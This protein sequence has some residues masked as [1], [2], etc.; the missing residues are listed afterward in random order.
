MIAIFVLALIAGQPSASM[1]PIDVHYQALPAFRVYT[2]CFS[3]RFAADPRG[4][5]DDPA[6]VM[7]ANSEALA[8]CRQV[9]DEQLARALE[10][11]TDYRLH[12]GSRSRAHDTIR[13]AFER[14]GTDLIVEPIAKVQTTADSG[15]QD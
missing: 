11:V 9:R 15:G 1:Q 13:H 3:D 7:Q 4:D 2:S 12:G 8:A 5:S 14:F 6:E 10:V